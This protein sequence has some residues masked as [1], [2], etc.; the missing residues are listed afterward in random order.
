MTRYSGLH[1]LFIQTEFCLSF[2]SGAFFAS[3]RLTWVDFIVF[4]LLETNIEFAKLDVNK[5]FGA[6]PLKNLPKL[7][8]FFRNFMQRPRINKHLRSANRFP[9]KIPNVP[10]E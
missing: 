1:F 2:Q 7:G 3:K 10:T 9:F 4:D 6:E 8:N 5:A